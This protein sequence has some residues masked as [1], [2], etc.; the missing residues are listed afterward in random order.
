M[1][2]C[3]ADMISPAPAAKAVKPRMRS[4]SISTIAFKNPR[5]SVS[6]CARSAAGR[7]MAEPGL[8]IPQRSAPR[9]YVANF[10]LLMMFLL[11]KHAMFGHDPPMNFRSTTATRFPSL[12]NVHA[13]SVDPAPSPRITRSYSSGCVF[14][15]T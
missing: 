6:A 13:A 4:R 3:T 8:A 1:A 9:K 14:R 2:I 15:S 5:V 10:A 7:S 11:G 12:A